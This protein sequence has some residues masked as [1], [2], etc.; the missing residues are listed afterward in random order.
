MPLR[1]SSSTA[2]VDEEALVSALER[3]YGP[4]S[5]LGDMSAIEARE[6]Y[7]ALLPR[8]LAAPAK[9]AALPRA[10]LATRAARKRRLAQLRHYRGGRR[11]ESERSKFA[12]RAARG[13]A[14]DAARRRAAS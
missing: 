9:P 8:A 7:K 1:A 11:G 5:F 10:R 14:E 6:L 4:T 3:L 13:G 2:S 12:T